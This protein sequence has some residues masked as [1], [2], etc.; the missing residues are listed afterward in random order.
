M[1]LP[2]STS[3]KNQ[4]VRIRFGK[5]HGAAEPVTILQRFDNVVSKFGDKPAL[6]QKVLI[7]VSSKSRPSN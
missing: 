7:P 6:H 1:D 5:G 3:E 4:P 2:Y